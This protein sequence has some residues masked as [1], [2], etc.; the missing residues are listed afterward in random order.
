MKRNATHPPDAF[1]TFLDA[2]ARPVAF[3]PDAGVA[4]KDTISVIQT[5][6]SA[7]LLTRTRAYKL[8]KPVNLEFLDYSSAERRRHFCIEECAINQ[9]LAPGVYLGV[10]PVISQPDGTPRFG[11]VFQIEQTPAIGDRI[12]EGAVTDFAVVMRRLPESRTLASL[13]NAGMANADLLRMVARATATFHLSAENGPPFA[14]Y[15]TVE[16][17][18]ANITQT[19]E[20]AEA[21]IGG[22]LSADAHA[23]DTGIHY[24]IHRATARAPRVTLTCG[25]GSRLSRRSPP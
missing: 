8:K 24:P 9:A 16:T 18:L 1:Q 5:H 20:Q 4:A 3:P 7:V 6:A 19:I 10:A 25:L 23:S 2:I 21:D 12:E 17:V 14:P 11:A 22:T 15:G 13:V